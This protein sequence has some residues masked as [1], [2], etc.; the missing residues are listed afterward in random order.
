VHRHG[1]RRLGVVGVA[2]VVLALLPAAPAVAAVPKPVT[3]WRS[4]PLDGIIQ[5]RPAI[6]GGTVVVATE[7][8]SLYG[9]SLRDGHVVWGPRH[10]GDPVPH[11]VIAEL[12]PSATQCGNIDP[13]GITSSLAVDAGTSPPRVFAVAEVLPPTG[14]TPVHEL[15]GVEATSGRVVVGP[16]PIDPPAMTH[17]EVEQ[18][19]AGLTVANGNIYVGFGGLYSD[20]G[21][22]HGFVVAAKEDGS[23]LAGAVELGGASSGNRGAGVW[24]TA[25][26]P[27][28]RDGTV[29][30]ATGNGIGSPPPPATDHSDAVLRLPATLGAVADEFQS[31]TFQSDNPDDLDLGS[32]APVLVGDGQVFELGKPHHAYLLAGGSLGGADRH[33][34]LAELDACDAYGSNDVLGPSVFVACRDGTE[35]IVIDRSTSPP[36]LRKGWTAPVSTD[37]PVVVGAGLVWAVD[38][39]SGVLYGLD[40]ATGRVVA[41]HPVGLDSSQHFPTASVGGGWVLVEAANRVAA[42]RV[43][44]TPPRRKA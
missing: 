16:T 24:A 40:P 19:R 2:G 20:C 25:P 21:D 29:L 32:T 3:S 13:L 11:A 4:P 37:G 33:T 34:P 10:V 17:P 7:H 27:V 14:R 9:L 28:D 12:S 35:Q 22:F 8:D 1:R 36:R 6:V 18:Q 43:V 44:T 41:K 31:P 39:S 30:V 42:F 5:G 15:V 23:G 38:T 26:P